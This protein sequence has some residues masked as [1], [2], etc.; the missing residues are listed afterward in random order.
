MINI[1]ILIL[2]ALASRGILAFYHDLRKV[3]WVERM[4]EK[5]KIEETLERRR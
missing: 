2:L 3:I 5:D 1:I 4:T